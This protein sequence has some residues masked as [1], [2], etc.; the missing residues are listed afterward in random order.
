MKW[1]IS[2]VFCLTASAQIPPRV[3]QDYLKALPGSTTSVFNDVTNLSGYPPIAFYFPGD[4]YGSGYW[5][6]GTT[7][8][9]S[10]SW[11]N[12][13]HLTTDQATSPTRQHNVLG[14]N[15][16][17]SVLWNG[18]SSRMKSASFTTSVN[19]EIAMV[20]RWND[21]TNGNNRWVIADAN[22][23][24]IAVYQNSGKLKLL[25]GTSAIA[26]LTTNKWIVYEFVS[27][28]NSSDGSLGAIIYTNG[29]L[30]ASTAASA[31]NHYSGI[32]VGADHWLIEQWSPIDIA[33]IVAYSG[34]T[35]G[36]NSTARTKLVSALTNYFNLS[37]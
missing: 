4:S 11:T 20:M 34:A 18:T 8:T 15:G 9:F 37:P 3:M 35:P 21:A 33:L 13:W 7:A 25:N 22:A 27:L 5:T 12:A 14:I 16:H 26:T 17:D 36:T 10:D 6:N 30:A 2:F 1:L 31:L 23:D 19:S 29:V 32:V 24:A 28:T